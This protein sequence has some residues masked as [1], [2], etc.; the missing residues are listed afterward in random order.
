MRKSIKKKSIRGF[1]SGDKGQR[2]FNYAYSIG[3]SIVILGSLFKILH[4]PGADLML[5]LGMGTEAAIFFL[6]SFDEPAKDY[7]WEQV[8]PELDD[9]NAEPSRGAR[10]G[11]Q[12]GGTVI[13]GGGASVAAASAEG[14]APVA[15]G[16]GPVI[17]GGAPTA[18]GVAA[19]QPGVAPSADLNAATEQ[20]VQQL[21]EM[22]E[23][24]AQLKTITASLSEAQRTLLESYDGLKGESGATAGYAEQM[25][26]L[27]RNISGLN[28][29]YEIQLK[30]VSSQL[31]TIDK[32]N[33]GLNNIRALYENGS[34]DSFRI[35]QETEHMTQTLAQLNAIYERMLQA[36]TVNMGF[37]SAAPYA[38][39]QAPY[40]AP[41]TPYGAPQQ[42]TAAQQYAQAQAQAQAQQAPTGRPY[43]QA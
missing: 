20:Y 8:F 26:A 37:Q 30:S 38:A 43:P 15:A 35:R 14:A 34:N 27:S 9:P 42:P 3:A 4:L 7:K 17:I 13:I 31:D 18:P 28:T 39:P 6:S 41:Q 10:P 23:Q 40:A 29:I 21:N 5:I 32:V 22:T 12:G 25:Q 19:I 16:N 1:F 11:V 24:L 2:T 33:A 36:M